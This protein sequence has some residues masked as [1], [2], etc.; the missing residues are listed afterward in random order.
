[1][2]GSETI[3]G[4][5]L[6]VGVDVAVARRCNFSNAVV[7]AGLEVNGVTSG[8]FDDG[9]DDVDDAGIISGGNENIGERL[10]AVHSGCG[11]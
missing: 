8:G 9:D 7:D 6:G 1:M 3:A 4:I 2:T 11:R 10:T 5:V